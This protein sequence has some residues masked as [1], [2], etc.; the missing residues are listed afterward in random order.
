MARTV[1]MLK[2]NPHSPVPRLVKAAMQKKES[3]PTHTRRQLLF[4]KLLNQC[5]DAEEDG[6]AEAERDASQEATLGMFHTRKKLFYKLPNQWPRTI[7][8]DGARQDETEAR[9]GRNQ[10][11][12]F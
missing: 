6:E 11:F 12:V 1:A 8:L 2:K 9:R 4:D 3:G 10:T 5:P 7:L